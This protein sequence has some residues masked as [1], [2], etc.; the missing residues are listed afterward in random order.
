MVSG[1]VVVDQQALDAL[2]A[3]FQDVFPDGL[4][5]GM[6]PDRNVVHPITLEPGAKPSY[7]PMYRLSPEEKAECEAQVKDLLEKGLI[8]PSSSPWGAPVFS[9]RSLTASCVCVA[10]SEC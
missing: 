5:P 8:Q 1:E 2:L 6:P 9:Y 7:R 3:R 4:P 10:I